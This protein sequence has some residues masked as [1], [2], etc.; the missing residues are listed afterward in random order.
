MAEEGTNHV[1]RRG[2]RNTHTRDENKIFIK[3]SRN[4]I[5]RERERSDL[6]LFLLLGWKSAMLGNV[7]SGTDRV[8]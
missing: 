3:I 7:L 2:R 1:G 6:S 5:E 8:L 4:K